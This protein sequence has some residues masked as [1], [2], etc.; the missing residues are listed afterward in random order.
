MRVLHLIISHAFAAYWGAG[1]SLGLVMAQVLPITPI[2][3]AFYA[4]T[5][6][7]QL[8]CAQVGKQECFGSPDEVPLWLLKLVF[9]ESVIK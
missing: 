3:V 5:W 7:R 2:G 8:H 1:L 6:P 4:A 9:D